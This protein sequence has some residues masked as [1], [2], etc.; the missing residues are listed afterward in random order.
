MTTADE[1]LGPLGQASPNRGAPRYPGRLR[2]LESLDDPCILEVW[3]CA[4]LE[5]RRAGDNSILRS[6]AEREP[7][8]APGGPSNRGVASPVQAQSSRALG[9]IRTPAVLQLPTGATSSR[10]RPPSR[11]LMNEPRPVSGRDRIWGVKSTASSRT[12][13][14]ILSSS[15]GR[16][17]RFHLCQART[18]EQTHLWNTPPP[19]SSLCRTMCPSAAALRGLRSEL[20]M[21]SHEHR[22]TCMFFK[23]VDSFA[24]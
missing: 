16:P 9:R 17:L 7:A 18:I 22:L 24:E 10:K 15:S 21:R 12:G 2:L 11:L 20:S 6:A 1:Y 14:N 4:L 3:K 5:I 19:D 8:L 23:R 13:S